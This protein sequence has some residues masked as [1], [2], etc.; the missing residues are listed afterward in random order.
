VQIEQGAIIDGTV[1]NTTDYGAFVELA[2]DVTGLIHISALSEEYVRRVTDIV[3]TGDRVKVEVLNIDDRGRYKLRRIEPE[4]SKVREPEQERAVE[5]EQ[6]PEPER[7]PRRDPETTRRDAE[8]P[9]DSQRRREPE[10]QREPERRRRPHAPKEDAPPPAV[11]TE[12]LQT[13]EESSLGAED[14]W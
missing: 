9:R 8:A 7:Q 11:E 1:T 14:R 6:A 2:P 12:P 4:G 3:R 13:E 10:A 5:P